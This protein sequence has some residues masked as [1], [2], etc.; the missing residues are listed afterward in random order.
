M[1]DQFFAGYDQST[2]F[3]RSKIFYIFLLF[4][5]YGLIFFF[6]CKQA[7]HSWIADEFVL[8]L[9]PA[10]EFDVRNLL[11]KVLMAKIHVSFSMLHSQR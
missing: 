5:V 1:M 8:L 6:V 10:H 7:L 4:L 3:K 9:L 2:E 11:Y